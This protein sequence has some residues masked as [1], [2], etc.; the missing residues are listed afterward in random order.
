ME[1]VGK[2]QDGA[3]LESGEDD[4]EFVVARLIR[5]E[6]EFDDLSIQVQ[7]CL[8]TIKVKDVV[9]T[10]TSIQAMNKGLK[11]FFAYQ[12]KVNRQLARN[13]KVDQPLPTFPPS[14]PSPNG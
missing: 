6:E 11:S 10:K 5:V 9:K 8:Q 7:G 4:E 12:V 2:E 1:E 3:E 14:P 13:A